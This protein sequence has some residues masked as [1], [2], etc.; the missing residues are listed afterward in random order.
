MLSGQNYLENSFIE[1]YGNNAESYEC[2]GQLGKPSFKLNVHMILGIVLFI[3][4]IIFLGTSQPR[5][6]KKTKKVESRSGLQVFLLIL[7]ILCF[8]GSMVNAG[9]FGYL[10]VSCY[11]PQHGQWFRGLPDDGKNLISQIEV[12][13]QTQARLDRIEA[14]QNK[15]ERMQSNSNNKIENQ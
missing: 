14:N 7:A 4:F 15:L 2:V 13:Q 11:M 9:I 3:G 8:I 10:F 1:K 12:N 5:K 6:D